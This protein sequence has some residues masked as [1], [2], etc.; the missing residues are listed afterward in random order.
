M[1]TTQQWFR[2]Y[3]TLFNQYQKNFLFFEEYYKDVNEFYNETYGESYKPPLILNHSQIIDIFNTYY[4]GFIKEYLSYTEN[5]QKINSLKGSSLFNQDAAPSL[6]KFLN[7]FV[8]EEPKI[9]TEIFKQW[10]TDKY[11][12]LKYQRE[13]EYVLEH[14]KETFEHLV[15]KNKKNKTPYESIKFSEE[16]IEEIQRLKAEHRKYIQNLEDS[17][18]EST[19]TLEHSLYPKLY[20]N[21]SN[22]PEI[23]PEI[24][25][26]KIEKESCEIVV[27]SIDIKQESV[28]KTS[29]NPERKISPSEKEHLLDIKI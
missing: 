19:D 26:E 25:E 12:L 2:E 15:E 17:I 1:I 3:N 10:E 18:K 28:T 6:Q 13:L 23:T 16:E 4:Q 24:V 22:I 7:G 20:K 9:T 27:V 21:N 29:I 5:I 8:I 14:L 11:I